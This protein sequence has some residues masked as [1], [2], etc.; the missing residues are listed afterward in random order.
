MA[1]KDI[2]YAGE[3]TLDE[4]KIISTTGN[5]FDVRDLVEQIEIFEDIYKATISGNI[6]LKDTTNIVAN[7]PIIGEERLILGLS[8]PQTNPTPETT[9]DY[10]QHPLIIYKINSKEDL[11]ERSEVISL[12][13][14]SI[15]GLRNSY[16]R[17]S[18][19]Y[20]G[21][22]SEI[23]DKILRD[24]TYLNSPKILN[25]EE[26][27][28][29]VK[30]VFPNKRPFDCIKHLTNISNS[31][32]SNTSPT[33]LF[34]ET[35]KGYHFRTFD[36]LS[37]QPPKMFYRQNTPT[38]EQTGTFNPKVGLETI[39]NYHIIPSRD[40]I[41]NINNGMISSKLI[42]HDFYNK[43]V[44]NHLYD[45]LSNFQQEIYPDGGESRPLISS[46]PEPETG[47]IITEHEDTRIF[48]SST[49]N[50]YN[51]SEEEIDDSG[52]K[53]GNIEYPYQSDNLDQTLQRK[54]SRLLQ[55]TGGITVNLEVNGT[56]A[57]QVG[58]KIYLEIETKSTM[59]NSIE[60]KDLTGAYIITR[61]KHIF[62]RSGELKH[63][64]LMQATKF[65]T[66]NTYPTGGVSSVGGLGTQPKLANKFT[67]SK[68]QQFTPI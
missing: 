54:T 20:K 55:M 11:Q 35:T 30:I 18:Q 68:I 8:T 66:R 27:S 10:T 22:P 52:N 7:F 46:S 1:Y 16:C 67:Q 21:Q 53:T 64:I 4:C 23:V 32:E 41:K 45:Y 14:G 40:T 3:F 33:Y 58:D 50:G 2:Q 6:I 26:T 62:L 28:N 42:A 38:L 29:L 9:V 5:A 61:L 63:T 24:E 25:V 31:K 34:Y 19:S 65:S 48:V 49:S 51:F 56:T 59:N 60:D 17:V 12:Q 43:K 13:F 36:G 39:L 37:M 57:L 15:E 44:D 47:K